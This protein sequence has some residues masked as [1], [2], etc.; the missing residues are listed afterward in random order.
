MYTKEMLKDQLRQGGIDPQGILLCHFSM[1]KIGEVEGGA[2]TVLDALSEYMQP[3]LLVIPAHT[4]DNINLENPVFDVKNTP[5]CIGVLPELFRRRPGVVRGVHPTHS[6]CALG[7]G[8]EALSRDQHKMNTPCSP[9]SSYGEL[10]RRN[11]QIL[12]VGVRFDRN[13]TLHCIE[14]MADVPNRLTKEPHQLY[15]IDE[16]GVRHSVPSYRHDNADSS[17]F[18]K[19]EPVMEHRGQ[20]RHLPFGQADCLLC[21]G[22]DLADTALELL[23][24]NPDLF[25]DDKPVPA[26]W[27]DPAL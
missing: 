22:K 20:L 8:A 10:V 4:W 18:V 16:A 27:Y 7:Q 23:A 26:E 25:A 15:A 1:K 11:A 5:V 17:F 12:L 24:K 13:T 14:E 9:H 6:L 3:G 19:L 21:R 2:E